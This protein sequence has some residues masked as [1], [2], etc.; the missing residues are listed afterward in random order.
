M[1]ATGT[2]GALQRASRD[3]LNLIQR[4]DSAIKHPE[5][6]RDFEGLGAVEKQ[7]RTIT[8]CA[9]PEASLPWPDD[10]DPLPLARLNLAMMY[11]DQGNTVQ[12]LRHSFQGKLVSRRRNGGPDWVNEMIA[13]VG[14]LI[15]LGSRPPTAA[16]LADKAFPSKHDILTVAYGYVCEVCRAAVKAFGSGSE[17][18]KVVVT[19]MT[20]AMVKK[21]DAKPGTKE[22]KE[23]FEAAQGR[24]RTWAGVPA[25][26]AVVLS[27]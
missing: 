19:M 26:Y 16:A 11:L 9:L 3:I 20:E 25:E 6:Y 1:G 5:I 23:Q 18:T 10:M 2:P 8:A 21:P 15:V 22:F 24:I 13:V 12:A 14:L 4:T 17:Y 7:L 27:A